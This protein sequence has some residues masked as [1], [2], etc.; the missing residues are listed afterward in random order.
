MTIDPPILP[1]S[2]KKRYA[3]R[4]GTTS[5]IYPAGYGTN[6]DRLGPH[7]DEIELL[8]FESRPPS[9]P[10]RALIENLQALAQTHAVTYNVHLPTDLSLTHPDRSI[11]DAA[12]RILRDFVA[13]LAPL[14]PTVHVLHLSPPEKPCGKKDL[15][16]WQHLAEKPLT[17]ILKTGLPCR[18]LA[19]ENLF[20]PFHWLAPLL[21]AF[22]LGV[23]LDTGHL[24]L[25]KGDLG[26]FLVD[27][28]HRI[29]I[30]HLHGLR[31]GR[32][33]GP[34]NDL[35]VDYQTP[36]AGWLG[37]FDG[38]VSL[39]VFGYEPLL[40]SLSWLDRLMAAGRP[41]DRPAKRAGR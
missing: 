13:L 15:L 16:A 14:N 21:E 41:A 35:P 40:A 27:Y 39:E 30:A 31:N 32:D 3:F 22:D 5:F 12:G 10:T 26:E 37:G 4:L 2:W 17:Q 28:G 34:L 9:R 6:V 38:S 25:Q 23:C 24:A 1:R 19:V 7:L 36:L 20:F 18:R 33:H 8:M 11:R 29:T